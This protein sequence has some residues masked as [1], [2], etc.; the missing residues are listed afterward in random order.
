M[1]GVS[2]Y[3]YKKFG[4]KL[5]LILLAT[6][7]FSVTYD[8]TY[9]LEGSYIMQAKEAVVDGSVNPFS[10]FIFD[11]T[12]FNV[13]TLDGHATFYAMKGIMAV[14]HPSKCCYQ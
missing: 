11:N 9:R 4:S 6:L 5:L 13:N 14:T 7:G 2:I 1:I 12:D 3:S 8:E 10:Q